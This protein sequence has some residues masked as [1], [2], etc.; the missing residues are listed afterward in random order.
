MP[1]TGY[2]DPITNDGPEFHSL[3]SGKS[4]LGP[5]G[6]MSRVGDNPKTFIIIH[7]H[8]HYGLGFA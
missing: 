6:G 1:H 7:R 8:H 4:F 2:A 5:L 3:V